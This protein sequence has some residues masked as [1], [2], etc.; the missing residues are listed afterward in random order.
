MLSLL[1]TQ[2]E[3]SP[4][5]RQV[6]V[7]VDSDFLIFLNGLQRNYSTSIAVDVWLPHRVGT[8]GM[9]YSRNPEIKVLAGLVGHSVGL[10]DGVDPHDPHQFVRD[11]GVVFTRLRIKQL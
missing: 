2:T 6:K 10:F 4:R 5:I 8:T 3:L 9:V 7:I 1:V 11:G